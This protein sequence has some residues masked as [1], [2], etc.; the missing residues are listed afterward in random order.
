MSFWRITEENN[1]AEVMERLHTRYTLRE[2]PAE[3]AQL[4]VLDDF[5]WQIWRAGL[6]LL[7][8]STGPLQLYRGQS[9]VAAAEADSTCRFWWELP[10]GDLAR[11]LKR[12]IGLRAFVPKYSCRIQS[13]VNS[14][15]N[16]DEK[17]VARLRVCSL[18]SVPAP[19][20]DYLELVPLRGYQEDYQQLGQLIEQAGAQPMEVSGLRE[21]LPLSGMQVE[22]VPAKPVFDLDAQE[23]TEAAVL[24]MLARLLELAG[25]HEAGIPE[26][27]DTE[28][29]HQCR[30]NL[31]K[32]RSLVSLFS[33]GLSAERCQRLKSALKTRGSA[34]N[35]L[36]DLDVFLLDSGD[37][38]N[39]L[40]EDF[41]P[42]LEEIF[43]HIQGRRKQVFEQTAKQLR[44]DSHAAQVDE[45]RET[46]QAAPDLEM[47]M[48]GVPIK[49]QVQKKIRKQYR[50]I[51]RQGTAIQGDT[52]DAAIHR[53]RIECK[54]L[55]YLLEL[56]AELFPRQRV[57]DLIRMLKRLQDNLGR[58]ND[59]AMQGEFLREYAQTAEPST[60]QQAS[61][62]A[63]VAVLYNRQLGERDRV[64]GNI[65]AFTAKKVNHLFQE[66]CAVEPEGKE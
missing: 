39:M 2:G 28:C 43:V 17:I 45:L 13:Q 3:E 9:L 33:K 59:Y 7:R 64:V 56:F 27:I 49:T 29:V 34:T 31:R 41:R 66:L 24:R 62:S 23:P 36:R 25:H 44:S 11:Q 48:S 16:E 52:P 50:H 53:L 21:L 5:D 1:A 18:L 12:V 6:L 32:A 35:T 20:L 47:P 63:L 65:T 61:I 14:L 40:P 4:A 30:V 37:Y 42:A 46:L 58:F 8:R 22:Y 51:C 26:D 15:L 19:A 10:E 54:K 60:A 55:R 38:R 57:K